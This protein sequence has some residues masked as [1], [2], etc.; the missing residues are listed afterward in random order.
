[1]KTEAIQSLTVTFEGHAQQTEGGV[2]YWLARDL[3]HLLGYT[4]WDN[5]LNAVSKAKTACDISGHEIADHF[6]DVGKM[7][8]LDSGGGSSTNNV[9]T[10]RKSL[11][12]RVPPRTKSNLVPPGKARNL[13][14]L[15]TAQNS[16]PFQ[17]WV[18][19][20]R[21]KKS[22]QGRHFFNEQPPHVESHIRFRVR[23]GIHVAV[24]VRVRIRIVDRVAG[25][26]VRRSDIAGCVVPS[27]TWCFGLQYLPTVETVGY[28]VSSLMGL[29]TR[30]SPAA[31][32]S[33]TSRMGRNAKTSRFG[34]MRI[35]LSVRIANAPVDVFVLV[36]LGT[37][38]NSPPFQRWVDSRPRIKKSRQGRHLFDTQTP[39]VDFRMRIRVRIGIRFGVCVRKR[40]GVRVVDRVVVR[41]VRRRD[42]VNCV[43]PNGTWRP[44]FRCLPTVET[45]GYSVSSLTGLKTNT[46]RMGLNTTHDL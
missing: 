25:R 43:V 3:Q 35:S 28:S 12:I 37:A 8:D 44:G 18:D 45:V 34:R 22:R 23:I 13:V 38:Q 19:A 29:K 41:I 46:S 9:L 10:L 20:P 4:K 11:S 7:V 33:I 30:S 36:P 6:A 17:R 16:P 21:M 15:G 39:N 27:G 5:F 1:M 31:R 40:I 14:P 24:C 26:F 32:K 42:V 2:E